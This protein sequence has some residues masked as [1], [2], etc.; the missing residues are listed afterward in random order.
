MSL[1]QKQGSAILALEDVLE[2]EAPCTSRS[3]SQFKMRSVRSFSAHMVGMQMEMT[4]HK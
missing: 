3:V 2:Q 4:W 1:K